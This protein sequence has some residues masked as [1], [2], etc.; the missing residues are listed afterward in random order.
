MASMTRISIPGI[1]FHV[2]YQEVPFLNNLLRSKS[3]HRP[4]KSADKITAAY[5]IIIA[6]LYPIF[7]KIYVF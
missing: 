5:L 7:S 6:K 2:L 4:S 1:V 3:N